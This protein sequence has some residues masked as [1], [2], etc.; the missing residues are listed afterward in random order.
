MSVVYTLTLFQMHPSEKQDGLMYTSFAP[1][2]LCI[3]HILL[4]MLF[5]TLLFNFGIQPSWPFWNSVKHLLLSLPPSSSL[6]PFLPPPSLP[7]SL[8]P[9]SSLLPSLSPPFLPPLLPFSTMRPALL[10]VNWLFATDFC[11]AVLQNSLEGGRW[12]PRCLPHS[13]CD[14]HQTESLEGW[15]SRACA[16]STTRWRHLAFLDRMPLT[17]PTLILLEIPMFL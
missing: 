4:C 1:P 9:L 3:W 8:L 6:F 16:A 10:F 5:K 12:Q 13:L 17:P 11:K 7:P 14:S 15:V 2:P